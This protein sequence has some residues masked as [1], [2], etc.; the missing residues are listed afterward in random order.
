MNE[1]NGYAKLIPTPQLDP[2]L[3]GEV[4]G[5]DAFIEGDW[6]LLRYWDNRPTKV[7]RVQQNFLYVGLEVGETFEDALVH[8]YPE[9]LGYPL[10]HRFWSQRQKQCYL[11]CHLDPALLRRWDRNSHVFVGKDTDLNVFLLCALASVIILAVSG[12]WLHYQVFWGLSDVGGNAL[13]P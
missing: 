8:F 7:T 10:D 6:V 12:F 3:M 9:E 4:M 11:R 2:L 13:N 1:R 5:S